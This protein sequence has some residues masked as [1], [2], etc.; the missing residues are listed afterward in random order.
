MESQRVGH[1][2]ATKQQ[3]SRKRVSA[4]V[5]LKI[6]QIWVDSEPSPAFLE[7]L[8]SWSTEYLERSTPFIFILPLTNTLPKLVYPI[9]CLQVPPFAFAHCALQVAA[10][11]STDR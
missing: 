3:Q 10:H 7:H 9:A 6:C 11:L 1:D 4:P 5:T 8:V 2:L